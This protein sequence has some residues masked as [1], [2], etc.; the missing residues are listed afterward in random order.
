M[1]DHAEQNALKNNSINFSGSN[2]Y[3]SMEP[4]NIKGKSKSCTKLIL[5][6]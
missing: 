5:K 4:C 3:L 1:E 2:I 6:K